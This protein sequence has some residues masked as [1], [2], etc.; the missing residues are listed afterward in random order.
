MS[1]NQT[2]GFIRSHFW[3][4]ALLAASATVAIY[5]VKTQRAPGAMTVVEAQAMDM[6][7]SRPPVG[8]QPV[9]VEAA[10]LRAVEG[11]STFP[12]TV[13]ALSDEEVMSRVPGRVKSVLVYAGDRVRA[14]QLLATIEA[15]EY[16]A[17][18]DEARLMA[19]SKLSMSIASRKEI[20]VS[21]AMLRSSQADLARSKAS[22]DRMQS[23]LEAMS[24]DKKKAESQLAMSQAE[25][26]ERDAD[27]TYTGEELGRQEKL[28]KAGAISLDELQMSRKERDMAKARVSSA[29]ATSKAMAQEVNIAAR[30]IDGAKAGIREAKAMI[31]QAQAMVAQNT[32]GV[33]KAK[34]MARTSQ[35][36]SESAKQGAKGMSAMANYRQVRAQA[37]GVVAE[38]I[39]SPGT[40][41]M[42]GQPLLRLMV[43]SRVRI[44]AELPQTMFPKAKVG[45]PVEIEVEGLEPIEAEL[46]SVSPEVDL[47]MRSFKVEAIVNNQDGKLASGMYAR[48]HLHAPSAKE[49]LAVRKEAIRTDSNGETYVWLYGETK[50]DGKD[51]DWTCTMHPEI[52]E[53]GP[54]ICPK[55]KMDLVP[56]SR[57]GK[58]AA[59]KRLVT[60]GAKNGSYTA[61][62]SGLNEGDKVIWAG[63]ENLQPGTPVQ[64]TKWGE[65]GPVELPSTDGST[66]SSS[67][68]AMSDRSDRSDK[69]DRASKQTK[70][71]AKLDWYC[72][73]GREFESDKPGSCPKC[74][75]DLVK[76]E[77]KK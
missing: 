27:L 2:K 69:S 74:G 46:T 13:Q 60:I 17:Q 5:I 40:V 54:G 77:A 31:A 37:D 61:I 22:Y 10:S 11:V 38:R 57:S 48:I 50:G 44:Q 32:A 21:Q 76:D 33:D 67:S 53:K 36:E 19:S 56:R 35:I 30:K 73:M 39:A 71:V 59:E 34:Q 25:I 47:E 26:R 14:G 63:H 24:L 7:T 29:R 3:T 28:Y 49:A 20:A 4:L 62:V 8:V 41:V 45:T 16:S 64:E 72:P 12:A 42:M 52:S 66:V 23:D 6:T 1:S 75:M 43:V 51:T 55:C 68:S 70:R 18:A 9:A 58:F 15:D 65:N